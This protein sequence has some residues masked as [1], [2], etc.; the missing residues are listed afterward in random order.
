MDDD[1]IEWELDKM[2]GKNPLQEPRPAERPLNPTYLPADPAMVARIYRQ[3]GRP[4]DA[5]LIPEKE[6][7]YLNG[8]WDDGEDDDDPRQKLRP[9]PLQKATTIRAVR[10]VEECVEAGLGPGGQAAGETADDVPAVV[11]K[12]KHFRW[13]ICG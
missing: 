8:G 9:L 4:Y 7:Y 12:A 6:R 11:G 10:P 13:G 1:D 2:D 5:S 3:M